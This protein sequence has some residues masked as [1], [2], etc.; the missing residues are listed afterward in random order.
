MY[1]INGNRIINFSYY[2]FFQFPN[3][4]VNL[5]SCTTSL[6]NQTFK[7]HY[8]ICAISIA[9]SRWLRNRLQRYCFYLD[10]PNFLATFFNIFYTFF[11]SSWFSALRFLSS[12]AVII[13]PL[14]FIAKSAAKVLLFDELTK[15][16]VKFF[17][18]SK[19]LTYQCG[20]INQSTLLIRARA[21][22]H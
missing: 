13:R 1:F 6:I 12:F 22:V 15:Y 18:S 19:I 4:V 14:A 11:V 5:L 17:D 3:W 16:L 10:W 8:L 21:R 7:D 20:K 2:T 9:H